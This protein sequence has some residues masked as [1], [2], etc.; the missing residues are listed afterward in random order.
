MSPIILALLPNGLLMGLGWVLRHAFSKEV[1][2]GI[3]K[4][5]FQLLFPV[6]IFYSASSRQ[7]SVAELFTIGGGALAITLTGCLLVLPLRKLSRAPASFVD[8]AG[9]AQ[10]CWRFNTAIA[11][12][13]IQ[14]LPEQSRSL[15]SIAIGFAVPLANI[16]AVVLLTHGQAMSLPETLKSIALNPFLIASVAGLMTAHIALHEI[17]INSLQAIANSATPLAL[18]SIGASVNLQVLTKLDVFS[19]SI[20][21]I[22]LI[23]LPTLTLLTAMALGMSKEQIIVLTIFS[24]LP[25]A[26]SAHLIASAFG[27][28]RNSVA[29][30][31]V[32]STLLACISLPLWMNLVV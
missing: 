1:W 26:S 27:A 18:L 29:T 19:L 30:V 16:L 5:N 25:T 13:A 7:P 2:H 15:M 24:A 23:L 6:L 21:A 17:L 3:D 14:A 9:V 12:V 32:Q 10:T 11:M 8:F 20:N 4:I 28:N 22:K 31:I